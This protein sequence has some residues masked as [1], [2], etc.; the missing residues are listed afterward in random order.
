[1]GVAPSDSL[2]LADKALEPLDVEV[3]PLD[4]Y[5]GLVSRRPDLRGPLIGAIH[6]HCR[7]LPVFGHPRLALP[8]PPPR[9][10]CPGRLVRLHFRS[11]EFG[12]I[13]DQIPSGDWTDAA[14]SQ[15]VN[16]IG[17]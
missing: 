12:T 2:Y 5:L 6:G 10:P 7:R 1:M 4:T 16:A 8:L 3:E 14:E 9:R 11:D 13:R 17:H 15:A